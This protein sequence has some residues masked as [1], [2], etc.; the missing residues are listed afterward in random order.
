MQKYI[1]VK[2]IGALGPCAT[3][4]VKHKRNAVN[5]VY[6]TFWL[7]AEVCFAGHMEVEKKTALHV[8]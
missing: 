8:M 5:C 2:M 6:L 4:T 3:S 1:N 7:Q